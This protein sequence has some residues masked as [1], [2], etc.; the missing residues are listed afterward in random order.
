VNRSY[1]PMGAWGE[2][3]SDVH[4]KCLP[5]GHYPAEQVPDETYAE[6]K[7]FFQS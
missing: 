5:C 1:K 3:A 6:L 7:A 4:G 2:R